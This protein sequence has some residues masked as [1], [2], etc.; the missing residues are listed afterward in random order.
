ME[1][2]DCTT[3]KY[4]PLV[5]PSFYRV[6]HYLHVSLFSAPITSIDTLCTLSQSF[7]WLDYCAQYSPGTDR[8]CD[9]AVGDNE[10]GSG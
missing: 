6:P 8:Y 3:D 5:W 2:N 9:W 1:I 10:N 7:L 4:C